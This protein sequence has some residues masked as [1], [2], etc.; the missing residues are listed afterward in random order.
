MIQYIDP[1]IQFAALVIVVRTAAELTKKSKDRAWRLY[2]NALVFS[3]VLGY[4]A[5][6][7]YGTHREDVDPLHGGGETVVDFEPAERERWEHGLDIFEWVACSSCV[8]VWL[9][10]KRRKSKMRTRYLK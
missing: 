5:A 10:L 2:L 7:Y 8:G 4:I 6:S 9:G 1:I 3:L